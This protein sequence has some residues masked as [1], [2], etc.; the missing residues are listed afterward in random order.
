MIMLF[1]N[2]AI[3][4]MALEDQPTRAWKF[5]ILLFYG[6]FCFLQ[7]WIFC[8]RK[9]KK[10]GNSSISTYS[11]TICVGTESHDIVVAIRRFTS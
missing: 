10:M 9:E 4:V 5:F 11:K 7:N 8:L 3:K 1:V 2:Y 6:F